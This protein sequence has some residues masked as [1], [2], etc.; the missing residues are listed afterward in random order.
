MEPT[1]GKYE[2]RQVRQAVRPDGSCDNEENCSKS[3]QDRADCRHLRLQAGFRFLLVDHGIMIFHNLG[4][5]ALCIFRSST[6]S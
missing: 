2:M 5:L 6:S 4:E 3:K 1:R